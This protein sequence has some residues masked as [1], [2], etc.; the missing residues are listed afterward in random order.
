MAERWYHRW[1]SVTRQSTVSARAMREADTLYSIQRRGL[2]LASKIHHRAR[3]SSYT[4]AAVWRLC[5]GG[6]GGVVVLWYGGGV[7]MS[8]FVSVAT[9]I[10]QWRQWCSGRQK[11]ALCVCGARA[12]SGVQRTECDYRVDG[13]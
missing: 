1:M 6:I 3:S 4:V 12:R 7:M 8:D 13:V 5:G 2:D 9:T 10:E 11:D